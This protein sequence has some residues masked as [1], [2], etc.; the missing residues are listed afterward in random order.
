MFWWISPSL[1]ILK[2]KPS[3]KEKKGE[4]HKDNCLGDENL[5]NG[6]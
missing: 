2:Y 3:K 1:Y 5:G 6:K 4:G